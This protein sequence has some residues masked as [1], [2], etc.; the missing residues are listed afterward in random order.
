M[1]IVVA[2]WSDKTRASE[3]KWTEVESTE[4]TP[5]AKGAVVEVALTR[6]ADV[7]QKLTVTARASTGWTCKVGAGVEA[8]GT[9]TKIDAIAGAP[10]PTLMVSLEPTNPD[11]NFDKPFVVVDLVVEDDARDQR[12]SVNRIFLV[13]KSGVL[14]TTS[15]NAYLAGL[16]AGTAGAYAIVTPG[17]WGLARQEL[18]NVPPW[19]NPE[20]PKGDWE[21]HATGTG[22]PSVETAAVSSALTQGS[23]NESTS[24]ARDAGDAMGCAAS[25]GSSGGTIP[26]A[27]LLLGLTW[28]CRRPRR[29]TGLA[30]VM[31]AM[32]ITGVLGGARTA[33]ASSCYYYGYLTFWD[34]RGSNLRVDEAGNRLGACEPAFTS[35]NSFTPGCC[36]A[37]IPNVTI[38]LHKDSL[39]PNNIVATSQTGNTGYF[40]LEDANCNPSGVHY[41]SVEYSRTG[42]PATQIITTSQYGSTAYRTALG[43]PLTGTAT[44]NYLPNVSVNNANDTNSS[45]GNVATTWAT[46]YLTFKSL[47]AEGETRYRR[48]YGSSNTYDLVLMRNYQVPKSQALCGSETI[49]IDVGDERTD[50][51]SHEFGHSLHGRVVGCNGAQPA[52][53]AGASSWDWS[54]GSEG[55]AI[56]EAVGSLV[57]QLAFWDPSTTEIPSFTSRYPCWDMSWNTNANDASVSR[58]VWYGLWEYIDTSTNNAD[59]FAD[60]VDLTLKDLF[61]AMVLWQASPAQNGVNRSSAEWFYTATAQSCASHQACCDYSGCPYPGSVCENGVCQI[62]DPHGNNVRDW[63]YWM[64]VQQGAGETNYARTLPSSPCLGVEDNTW[65]FNGGFRLD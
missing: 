57:A 42:S 17:F 19:E 32:L 60:Y 18:Q 20:L 29:L 21:Q 56:K 38:H 65:P 23:A 4:V 14:S 48:S 1:L 5:A 59:S 41:L 26:F 47:D 24:G 28:S 9:T 34:S 22:K 61:D 51:P 62:G 30:P 63:V 31:T 46:S 16:S 11:E 33:R 55:R 49:E 7:A 35:C 39:N 52:F 27:L 40:L 50:T 10:I 44:W 3:P 36:F 37:G 64:A 53:P 8:L 12:T 43:T 54:G 45:T 6:V 2:N 58:N 15:Y 13:D 25:G